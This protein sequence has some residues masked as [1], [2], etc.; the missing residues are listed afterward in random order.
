[1][2]WKRVIDKSMKDY[3]EVDYETKT[4]RI[5]PS[6]GDIVNTL[7][8]ENLHIKY[9]RRGEKWIKL[10]TKELESKLTIGQIIKLLE[11]YMACKK[12]KGKKK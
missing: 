3:G 4:V 11:K 8:H 1:M 2:K 12:G 10:K 9:P 6:R 7:I 5:N